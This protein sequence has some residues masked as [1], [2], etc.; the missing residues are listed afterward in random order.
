MQKAC[1]LCLSILVLHIKNKWEK[2]E[3][4]S[5]L[6]YRQIWRVAPL[7]TDIMESEGMNMLHVC[8]VKAQVSSRQQP[9]ILLITNH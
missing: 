1:F 8:W 7:G 6:L 2:Q 4:T 5:E 9:F 3:K